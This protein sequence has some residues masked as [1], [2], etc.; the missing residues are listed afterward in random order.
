M[1]QLRSARC[2]HDCS[3]PGLLVRRM[4]EKNTD[5]VKTWMRSGGRED[6]SDRSDAPEILPSTH[7][8]RKAP[9]GDRRSG[10]PIPAFPVPGPV[11]N[12]PRPGPGEAGL[13]LH[14]GSRMTIYD[15]AMA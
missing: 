1:L 5:Y 8:S 12:I 15:A 4:R 7:A 14:G 13:H 9:A 6:V 2:R 11:G 10:R 3:H